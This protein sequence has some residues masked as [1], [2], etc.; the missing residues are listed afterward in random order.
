LL[1][2]DRLGFTVDNVFYGVRELLESEY[3]SEGE[4]ITI[5]ALRADVT[6]K[7]GLCINQKPHAQPTN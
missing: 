2:V 7:G 4:N 3:L 1:E 6:D 5:K